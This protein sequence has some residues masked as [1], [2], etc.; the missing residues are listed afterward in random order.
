MHRRLRALGGNRPRQD[1]SAQHGYAFRLDG[2]ANGTPASW[3]LTSTDGDQWDLRGVVFYGLTD[4]LSITADASGD[5]LVYVLTA[6]PAGPMQHY[7]VVVEGDPG[8]IEVV[9]EL[10]HTR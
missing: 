4:V 5:N 9:D 2:L 8:A 3:R 1:Q 6:I 7:P 10:I